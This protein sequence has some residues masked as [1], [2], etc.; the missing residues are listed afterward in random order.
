MKRNSHISV[1]SV[2]E[3]FSLLNSGPKE[4]CIICQILCIGYLTTIKCLKKFHSL[5]DINKIIPNN[6]KKSKSTTPGLACIMVIFLSLAFLCLCR[7][8]Y[9]SRVQSRYMGIWLLKTLGRKDIKI[10]WKVEIK[11]HV[12]CFS[13]G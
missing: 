6:K 13:L 5:T 8:C 2:I 3:F 12:T 11:P 4:C 10:Y 1:S 9:C 7:P